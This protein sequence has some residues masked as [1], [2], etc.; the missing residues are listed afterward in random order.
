MAAAGPDGLEQL[1]AEKA[2]RVSELRSGMG[3]VATEGASVGMAP[4]GLEEAAMIPSVDAMPPD[5]VSPQPSMADAAAPLA[6]E[7]GDPP[8]AV[9]D[10][11]LIQINSDTV[12][13]AST[14]LVD[15]G[16]LD[17]VTNTVTPRMKEAVKEVVDRSIPGLLNLD[18]ENDLREAIYGI[19]D[20]SI[21]TDGTPAGLGE[22]P[23]LGAGGPSFGGGGLPAGASLGPAGGAAPPAILGLGGAPGLQG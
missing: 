4:T 20:G 10:A 5:M 19:A 7:E 21:P 18:S 12:E 14:R 17:E 3:S 23:A 15:A 6:G 1:I 8:L 2:A 11:P 22:P 9:E 13:S 16:L